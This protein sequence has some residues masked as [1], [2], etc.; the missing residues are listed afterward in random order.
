MVIM[1]PSTTKDG[2]IGD[3]MPMV[4]MAIVSMVV[5]TSTGIMGTMDLI[6][7]SMEG[8]L[9]GVMTRLV[10]MRRN[11]TRTSL[12]ETNPTSLIMEAIMVHM[13]LELRRTGGDLMRM[14]VM[15]TLIMARMDMTH[16]GMEVAMVAIGTLTALMV[17]TRTGIRVAGTNMV[18]VTRTLDPITSSSRLNRNVSTN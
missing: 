7:E 12:G 2:R 3:Q 17:I 1:M 14:A 4:I 8:N 18:M 11:G 5:M 16:R 6:G 10:D 13:I 15:D 9:T